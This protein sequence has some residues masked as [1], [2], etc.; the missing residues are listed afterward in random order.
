M[1]SKDRN[2]EPRLVMGTEVT[3]IL[4]AVSADCVWMC[5]PHPFTPNYQLRSY[6]YIV[7]RV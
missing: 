4:V 3:V 6:V 1:S 7:V 2:T 5:H